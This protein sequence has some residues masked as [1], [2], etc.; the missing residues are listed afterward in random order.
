MQ[1]LDCGVQMC[2]EIS[3][4]HCVQKIH[5]NHRVATIQDAQAHL[6]VN[7]LP[8]VLMCREHP[9]KAFEYYDETCQ[10]LL[11]VSCAIL[12]NHIDHKCKSIPEAARASREEFKQ[13]IEELTDKISELKTQ[14]ISTQGVIEEFSSLVHL[15]KEAVD[16]HFGRIIQEL[17]ARR[18]SLH[19]ILR[20]IAEK[21]STL[22]NNQFQSGERLK[23]SMEVLRGDC[24]D[25]VGSVNDSQCLMK[26][27]ESKNEVAKVNESFVANRESSSQ[28]LSG[29]ILPILTP[30]PSLSFYSSPSHRGFTSFH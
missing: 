13:I 21:K 24:I 11:C 20:G 12:G 5:R 18:D 16:E 9:D 17:E 6:K 4:V 28:I 14:G 2:L 29:Q 1:C 7:P 25:W 30:F 27:L 8:V 10:K 22:L 23:Q 26:L 19:E 15:Q 3:R